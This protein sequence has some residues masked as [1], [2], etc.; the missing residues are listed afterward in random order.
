M[1]EQQTPAAVVTPPRPPLPPSS[2][3]PAPQGPSRAN[4]NGGKAAGAEE[5]APRKLSPP[6]PE[7]MVAHYEAQGMEPREASLRVIRD[8]QTILYRA[9]APGRGRRK[10]RFAVDAGRKVDYVNARL[11]IVEMK[12]DSKPGYPGMLAVGAAAGAA[13]QGMA[14]AAPHVLGAL[15]NVWETV[16][17]ATTGGG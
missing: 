5:G 3:P 9:V 16:R 4:G 1:M 12:L 10:D 17:S 11:A 2:A 13:L 14:A 8:L 7:E 15:G 6:T